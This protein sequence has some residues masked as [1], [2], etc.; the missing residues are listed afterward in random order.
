[1]KTPNPNAVLCLEVNEDNED[2]TC[3]CCGATP[4]QQGF[5]MNGAI[6]FCTIECLKLYASTAEHNTDMLEWIEKSE[7]EA[8]EMDDDDLEYIYYTEWEE[9]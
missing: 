6:Y 8:D 5:V 3:K 2:R 1:M 7:N 4:I 9:A